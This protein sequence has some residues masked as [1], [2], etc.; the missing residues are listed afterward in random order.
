MGRVVT[1]VTDHV[2]DRVIHNTLPYL[3]T[4]Y[5]RIKVSK[6]YT[7]WSWGFIVKEVSNQFQKFLV[8]SEDDLTYQSVWRDTRPT[9][10]NGGELYLGA[11]TVHSVF[12]RLFGQTTRYFTR[13]MYVRF[14]FCISPSSE[15]LV[16]VELLSYLQI[17]IGPW[18]YRILVTSWLGIPN[19]T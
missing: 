12:V 13:V 1:R 15:V 18:S 19:R 11:E 10:T 14:C 2:T 6:V 7:G 17:L 9:F 3:G 8:P 5:Q 4:Y 16:D